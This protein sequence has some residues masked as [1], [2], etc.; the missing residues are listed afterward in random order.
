M[1]I[2]VKVRIDYLLDNDNG[3]SPEF[4]EIVIPE[5]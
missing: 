5:L 1:W 3:L 2:M 4:G